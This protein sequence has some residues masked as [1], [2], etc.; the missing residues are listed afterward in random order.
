MLPLWLPA[1]DST[2]RL[3]FPV[4]GFSIAALEAPPGPT[5]HMPLTMSLPAIEEFSANVNVQIHPYEG[6]IE[7]YT[8]LTLKQFKDFGLKVI[9][10]KK[11]GKSGVVFQYSGELKGGLRHWYARSEKV[12]EQVYLVTATAA[13][14]QWADQAS[15]LKACVDSFR[16]EKGE[17]VAP[18]NAAPPHR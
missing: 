5:P 4:A 8:A 16:L 10:Q 13:E 14:K 18:P 12:G 9:E 17:Q 2:N 1:A 3:R 11:V 7:E 15:Q 6:S